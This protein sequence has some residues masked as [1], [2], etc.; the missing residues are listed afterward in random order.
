MR[1]KSNS[2]MLGGWEGGG[3]V[4]TD[5]DAAPDGSTVLI[6]EEMGPVK[7]EEAAMFELV[8]VEATDEER[9]ALA[10]AGFSLAG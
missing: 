7:P 3:T 9:A 5:L 4:G 2:E 10:A 8:I 6:L 1:L